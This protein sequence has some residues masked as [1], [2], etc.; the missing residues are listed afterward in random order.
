MFSSEFEL[1]L[2]SGSRIEAIVPNLVKAV[3]QHVLYKTPQE[4][5]RFEGCELAF[6]GAEGDG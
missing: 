5:H 6:L 1:L 2:R 3:W 4:F